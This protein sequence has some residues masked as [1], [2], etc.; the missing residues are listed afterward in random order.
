[1]VCS[2]AGKHRAEIAG[3]LR[4]RVA[5]RQAGD[6]G[7]IMCCD[8]KYLNLLAVSSALGLVGAGSLLA[9]RWG[10]L[11]RQGSLAKTPRSPRWLPPLSQ[12]APDALDERPVPDHRAL[13]ADTYPLSL[14][15][16]STIW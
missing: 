10:A 5:R 9:A 15:A 11:R 4:A 16:D 3:T 6:E 2:R 14:R 13:R 12:A 1:M 8:V 7:G